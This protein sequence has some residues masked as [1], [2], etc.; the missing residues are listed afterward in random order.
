M[1]CND[2]PNQTDGKCCHQSLKPSEYDKRVKD[3]AANNDA[4]RHALLMQGQK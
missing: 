1:E 2:C 3:E 4:D